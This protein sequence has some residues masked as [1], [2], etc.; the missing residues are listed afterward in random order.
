MAS[1]EH[2]HLWLSGFAFLW[3]AFSMVA[4]GLGLWRKTE[5]RGAPVL[6]MQRMSVAIL[7]PIHN[8]DP[9]AVFGN[10]AALL[11]DLAA[12]KAAEGFSL[13]V[14]SDT[15][16]EAIAQREWQ[17]FQLLQMEQASRFEI[18]YRR[19]AENTD[20]K[21]GNIAD[22]VTGWGA[23][24]EAMLVLDA[25]SLMSADAVLAMREVLATDPGLGLVQTWPRI[26][27]A[28]GMFARVQQFVTSAHGWLLA[29]GLQAWTGGSANYWGH[30][31]IIRTRAFA[32]AA[33]L[34]HLCSRITRRETLIMSH[35]FVEAAMLRRAGWRVRFL[36]EIDGSYEETPTSLM[37]HI[38]RDRRWCRGNL[39]HLRLLAARGLHPV[40]RFHLLQG[41]V[42]YL[43]APVWLVLMAIW[44]V[45]HMSEMP[46]GVD[47]APPAPMLVEGFGS[48]GGLL[49]VAVLLMLL[50]PKLVSVTSILLSGRAKE[51]GGV[52]TFLAAALAEIAISVIY[53]PILMVQQ[54]LSVITAT[55]SARDI[56]AA[57]RRGGGEQ[58]WAV[59]L[60]F[61]LPETLLGA[62]AVIGIGLGVVTPWLAPIAL[63]LVLAVPLSWL[64]DRRTTM[65]ASPEDL[66][67]PEI[68]RRAG[69]ARARYATGLLAAPRYAVAAE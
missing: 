17:A 9:A 31:A 10:A 40:S 50:G 12:K 2:L 68:A 23:R 3:I 64:S 62:T 57:Q 4:A 11:E 25:D 27:R 53:A 36:P 6:P 28:E 32:A 39:Q 58:S 54:V 65:L 8:E 38:Q 18:F 52:G 37:D 29:R 49:L 34:P 19:R 16:D 61:H 7:I 51:F 43:L 13:Y 45:P 66:S 26:L 22:W 30:N 41:A 44:A 35:D 59:L 15:R 67:L 42:S 60:R 1:I 69:T 5:W 56:W 20:R 46:L 63:S 48:G 47:G 14:L 21:T 33:G 24:H 55:V